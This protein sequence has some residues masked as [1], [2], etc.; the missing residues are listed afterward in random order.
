MICCAAMTAFGQQVLNKAVIK[1]KIETTTDNSGMGDGG[2][3]GAMVQMAGNE[4]DI[5]IYI[6]DSLRKVVTENNFMNNIIIT[7]GNTGISTSL[8][9]SGGEKNGY[10]QTREE[11]DMQRKRMDSIMKARENGEGDNGGGGRVVVRMGGASNVVSIDYTEEAKE[12]NKI[13][14]KKAVVTTKK[15]DGS[16]QKIDVWYSPDYVLPAGVSMGR[17]G[18][19]L[20]ELKGLPVM[21]ETVNTINIGNGEMTM[22]SHYE[23]SKLELNTEIADKEFAIPKGYTI[24]TYQ[25]YIK[26][27]P[28]GMPGMRRMIRVGG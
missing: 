21:Y 13:K 18:L 1:A 22:T 19:N 4:T 12:I 28:D 15:Q 9:E 3:G 2:G 11:R 8:T 7:D 20:S 24:K 10:T 26:D 5:K 14:C 27:N 6:K 23:I 16:L 25:E 17:G